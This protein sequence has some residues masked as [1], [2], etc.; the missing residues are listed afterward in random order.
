MIKFIRILAYPISLIYGLILLF[1]NKLFDWHILSSKSYDTPIIGVGNLSVGGTG[2][3]PHVEYLVR[4]LKDNYKVAILSR[5]Y[6]RKTKGFILGEK[7]MTVN[8][9]GDEA[10]QYLSKFDNLIIAVCEKRRKGIEKILELYPDLHVILLDDAFQ[11]RYVKPGLNILLS[12]YS[13]L[14]SENFVMPT[15]NLREFRNGAQRANTIIITKSPKIL[16]PIVVKEY[17]TRLKPTENQKVFFSYIDFEN[18]I[19]LYKDVETVMP[20]KVYA[21]LMITGIANPY[22][23]EEF[24]KQHCVE[25]YKLDYRDHHNYTQKDIDLIIKTY[26]SIYSLNKIIVTTEKDSARLDKAEFQKQFI[27][28]PIFYMP[29]K[30]NIHKKYNQEFDQQ[31]INYVRTNQRN[32]KLHQ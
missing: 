6:G 5:G 29:I 1:R 13:N 27:G 11:H 14:Y 4:L 19:P 8:E 9:L 22:P 24:L 7:N 10:I 16:S 28:I 26:N 21:I 23:L 20:S 18:F 32:S 17:L 3:T 30:I 12:D 31:I 2:K 25:L 15:G